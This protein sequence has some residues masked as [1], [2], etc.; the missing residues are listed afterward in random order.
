MT[1]VSVIVPTYC[2]GRFL[3]H[4]LSAVH[5]QTCGDWEVIVV[6]DCGPED[7]TREAVARFAEENPRNRVEYLRNK[8]NLGCGGSRNAGFEVCRGDYIALLDAD[9]YWNE[10]YLEKQVASVGHNDISFT[11]ARSTDEK[12]KDLGSYP[13]KRMDELEKGFPRTLYSENF[14]LP[15]ATIFRRNILTRIGNFS[16][17]FSAAADW[18]FYLRCAA[19]G[20]RFGFVPEELCFYRRHGG[21]LTSNYLGITE[22]CVRVLRENFAR[23]E[24]TMRDCLRQSLY[25]HVVR[26]AYLK[27]S[28]RDWSGLASATEAFFLRPLQKDLYG[29]MV[30]SMKNNWQHSS[31]A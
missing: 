10:R 11:R 14:L 15:S 1:L 17:V 28:F 26:L 5:G 21:A 3:P 20:L 31:R 29:Q 8:S 9:D 2:M 7:G 6:D 4:A 13:G 22:D 23:S 12:G 24:G 27:L 18:D 19:G 16:G 25:T 30:K